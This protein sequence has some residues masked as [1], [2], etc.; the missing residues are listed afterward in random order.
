MCDLLINEKFNQ[1]CK[2]N[3]D[4]ECMAKTHLSLSLQ[5]KTQFKNRGENNVIFSQAMNE[6]KYI[7]A[8]KNSIEGVSL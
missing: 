7:N 8:S 1:E 6:I 2:K 3:I 5:R 4:V